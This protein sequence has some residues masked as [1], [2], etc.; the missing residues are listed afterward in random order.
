MGDFEGLFG[1]QVEQCQLVWVNQCGFMDS[2]LDGNNVGYW[3][4]LQS[5]CYFGDVFCVGFGGLFGGNV[6]LVLGVRGGYCCMIDQYYNN[7]WILQI[8]KENYDG[9]VGGIWYL[10]DSGKLFVDLLFGFDYLQNNICGLFFILLDF[11][12]VFSG[13]LECWYWLFLFEEIGG[14]SSNNSKWCEMFWI[15]IFG[16]SDCIVNIFWEYE[17]VV[18]CF[19]YCSDCIICYILVVGIFDLYLGCKFGECD[20]YLVYDFDLVCFGCLLSEEEWCSLWCNVIQY[21]EFYLQI[22]SFIGNGELFDL[23][24]GLVVFVGVLEVGKQGY[25]I[26]FD[27]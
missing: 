8:K 17:L 3:L 26:C 2:Y 27:L 25:R 14:K 23:L 1:L 19:E 22:Y 11:I 15:G 7:Y 6:V 12:N 21:S 24:V 13:D 16:Y 18:I 10:S 5:G 9:Y 20:G 4:N